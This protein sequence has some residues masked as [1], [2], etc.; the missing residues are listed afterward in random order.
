MEQ[1]AWWRMWFRVV[2]A[3]GLLLGLAVWA[4][5][6]PENAERIS[7][8]AQCMLVAVG[9]AGARAV[10]R[11]V[12]SLRPERE[13]TVAA[14]VGV[15]FPRVVISSRLVA[16]LDRDALRAVEAHEAAHARHRD[17]LRIWFAQIATDV[18]WPWQSAHERFRAWRYAL[19]LARD[20]EALEAGAEGPDLASA[21]VTAA[22]LQHGLPLNAAG[23]LSDNVRLQNRI[24]ILLGE[25]DSEE[26]VFYRRWFLGPAVIVSA[27]GLW[28]A[29]GAA[30]GEG[31]VERFLLR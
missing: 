5:C 15:F 31:I 12:R 25:R 20:E 6:E 19:E 21:I 27:L 4:V 10:S 2:P 14:T 7:T 1:A 8:A 18:L 30:A 22:R 24:D 29:C 11:S 3:A 17:P 13:G 26:Q 28:I 16:V 9:A 23:L